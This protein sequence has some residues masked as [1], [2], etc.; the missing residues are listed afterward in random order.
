MES[1]VTRYNSKFDPALDPDSAVDVAYHIQRRELPVRNPIPRHVP[2]APD[3][4]TLLS[5][6]APVTF[7]AAAALLTVTLDVM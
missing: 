3:T 5:P 7:S 2:A 6:L 4:N 1:S